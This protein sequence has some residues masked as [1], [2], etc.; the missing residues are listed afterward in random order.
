M[1]PGYPQARQKSAGMFANAIGGSRADFER[2]QARLQTGDV[3]MT[4]G[5]LR[6][7]QVVT[8]TSAV[9]F[10]VAENAAVP[11]VTEK[12]LKLNDAFLA[13][14]ILIGYSTRL[15]AD[16]ISSQVL[17]SFPNDK[18]LTTAASLN[19][20]RALYNS[21]FGIRMNSTVL[22]DGLDVL[23]CLRAD[24]AQSGTAVSA[25]A[26]TGVVGQSFWGQDS[27]FKALVPN[28]LFNGTGN[29][30]VVVQLPESVTFTLAAT[31]ISVVCMVRGWLLQ[32]GGIQ[33]AER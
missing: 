11:I 30:Q 13:Q 19:A 33:R 16:A 3:V 21:Q 24:T 18:V 29:N 26:T 20:A 23:A 15:T 22:I 32:N 9:T 25:V 10:T 17:H 12:R 14:N 2:M 7:E 28:V 6:M 4:P 31:T 5:Y 8:T 27:A 1:P